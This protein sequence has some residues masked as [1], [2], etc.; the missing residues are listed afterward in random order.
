MPGFEVWDLIKVPFPSPNRPVHQRRP[1]LVIAIP[2]TPGGPALLWV[3]MVTSAA[4]RGWAGD[5]TISDLAM[6]GLPAA[7]M[8]RS[9]KIA[10]IEAADAEQIGC[11][12]PAD[13][14]Q[15]IDALRRHLDGV[16]SRPV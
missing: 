10:T 9:A 14:P 8:V 16:L 1:A 4:N 15:V 5:V 2:D 3:L 12:P 6:A 11:L 13:R 7:S